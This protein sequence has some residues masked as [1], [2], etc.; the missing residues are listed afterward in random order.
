MPIC[1]RPKEGFC[2]LST[3]SEVVGALLNYDRTRSKFAEAGIPIS[4]VFQFRSKTGFRINCSRE[5]ADS[6]V[7]G[8]MNLPLSGQFRVVP[9]RFYVDMEVIT[10]S[11]V[12][13]ESIRKILAISAGCDM[14]EVEIGSVLDPSTVR[15]RI[16]KT[17]LWMI[18]HNM[19]SISI[20]EGGN[21]Y[22]VSCV[23]SGG[24]NRGT[25]NKEIAAL[26]ERVGVLDQRISTN[27]SGISE[28]REMISTISSRQDQY[29][30]RLD[31]F[32]SRVEARLERQVDKLRDRLETMLTSILSE[33]TIAADGKRRR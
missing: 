16:L 14:R 12:D 28:S 3:D 33:S 21:R 5:V 30:S 18:F 11:N 17:D 4:G 9:M 24:K 7:G 8:S 10:D 32:E 25:S 20:E 2:I 31:R 29:E 19:S 26:S 13:T 27:S 1:N 15:I 6:V 22:K 23:R